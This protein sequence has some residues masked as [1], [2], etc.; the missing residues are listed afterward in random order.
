MCYISNA[1]CCDA[2]HRIGLRVSI[3]RGDVMIKQEKDKLIQDLQREIQERSLLLSDLEVMIED[4]QHERQRLL[5]E[6]RSLK[7]GLWDVT[8][9]DVDYDDDPVTGVAPVAFM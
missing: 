3:T 4:Y 2:G 5:E 9:S 7:E 8:A 6:L 1:Q